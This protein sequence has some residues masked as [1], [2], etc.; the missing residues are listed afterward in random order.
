MVADAEARVD[1][2]IEAL[3]GRMESIKDNT[4]SSLLRFFIV[5]F[6]LFSGESCRF[7]INWIT[8]WW[9]HNGIRVS[10]QSWRLAQ[11]RLGRTGQGGSQHQAQILL[12]LYHFLLFNTVYI[13]WLYILILY[14]ILVQFKM[15]CDA[16]NELNRRYIHSHLKTTLSNYYKSK[17]V[18]HLVQWLGRSVIRRQFGSVQRPVSSVQSVPKTV[19]F[20]PALAY[21]L[22]SL[23]W[24]SES[25]QKRT[26][27]TKFE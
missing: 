12:N 21:R 24:V 4:R 27:E 14:I 18:S 19:P 9:I 5:C 15:A 26:S 11:L 7:S 10:I 13:I 8:N 17:R 20:S 22:L 16:I 2:E 6:G 1:K 3:T 25:P 23:K